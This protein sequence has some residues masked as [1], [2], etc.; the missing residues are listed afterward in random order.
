LV[1]IT[2]LT[3]WAMAGVSSTRRRG[4]ESRLPDDDR[5]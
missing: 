5:P 3:V 1:I 4:V 2:S